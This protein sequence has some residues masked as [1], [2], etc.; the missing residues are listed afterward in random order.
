MILVAELHYFLFLRVG[1]VEADAADARLG[2]TRPVQLLVRLVER[3]ALR[4]AH[5][6]KHEKQARLVTPNVNILPDHKF[7]VKVA[8]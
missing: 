4:R 3:Q 5:L 6:W 1:S 7:P 2:V 8:L